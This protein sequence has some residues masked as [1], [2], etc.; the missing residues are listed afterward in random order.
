MRSLV[1]RTLKVLLDF[2]EDQIRARI[3]EEDGVLTIDAPE[4]EKA[5]KAMRRK[6]SSFS[7]CLADL[8][9]ALEKCHSMSYMAISDTVRERATRKEEDS[10]S[11][12]AALHARIA[13]AMSSAK[14]D[15]SARAQLF[16]GQLKAAAAA[17]EAKR[18][19]RVIEENPAKAENPLD[20]DDH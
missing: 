2:T 5:A 1:T 17:R 8:A 18:R 13:E 4:L 19:A 16:D 20:S 12:S 3:N 15:T 7:R 14:V 11:A 6:P 9:S 10:G